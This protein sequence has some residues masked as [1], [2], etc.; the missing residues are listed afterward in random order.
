[1]G[2]SSDEIVVCKLL[3]WSN[4]FSFAYSMLLVKLDWLKVYSSC[5]ANDR[6][7]SSSVFKGFFYLYILLKFMKFLLAELLLLLLE[8]L[9]SRYGLS[10][11][12]LAK[13]SD[14][15]LA[16]RTTSSLLAWCFSV[17]G[18]VPCADFLPEYYEFSGDLDF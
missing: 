8:A 4:A 7:S 16:V 18:V 1:M 6:R 14:F 10:L 5:E 11:L 9:S 2:S 17:L 12:W 13:S 3:F 15:D